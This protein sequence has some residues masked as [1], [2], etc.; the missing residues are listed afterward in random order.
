MGPI[1]AVRQSSKE[2]A[3]RRLVMRN[4]ADVKID[5]LN[6][7]RTLAALTAQ[8]V[9][10]R[11]SGGMLTW[12]WALIQP[13]AQIGLY[14]LIF[15]TLMAPSAP[16]YPSV[17]SYLVYL[18]SGYFCWVGFSEAITLGAISLKIEAPLLRA[19]SMPLALFPLKAAG[20][21]WLLSLMGFSAI[22]ALAPFLGITPSWHW[23]LLPIPWVSLVL[24]SGGIAVILA[25]MTVLAR[26]TEQLIRLAL[27]LLFWLTPIVYV[28]SVL[29][30]WAQSVLKL[31]P[32]AVAVSAIHEL[33][34]ADRMPD[35][36][37]W[38]T[39]LGISP[40][41]FGLGIFVLSR[42]DSEVRDAL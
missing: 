35:A 42:F 5:N 41:V 3:K 10:A 25:P 26:D 6:W 40:A 28:A 27:P 31:N 23:L 30:D 36:T 12:G 38:G 29:P 17:G 16:G 18:C 32:L 11:W 2:K 4:R 33:M 37:V 7:L 39:M 21:A 15:G 14:A 22:L 20:A 24:L 8:D 34:L 1:I 13:V 9:R 19:R